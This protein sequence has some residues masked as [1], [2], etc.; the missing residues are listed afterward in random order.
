M[1]CINTYGSYKCICE[2]GFQ[3]NGDQCL[4]AAA[5]GKVLLIMIFLKLSVKFLKKLSECN[6]HEKNYDQAYAPQRNV[7]LMRLASLLAK[8][9]NVFV[10]LDS[11]VFK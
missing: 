6:Y 11:K 2:D 5:P 7:T 8:T 3:Q 4:Q 10:T 1:R 9:P